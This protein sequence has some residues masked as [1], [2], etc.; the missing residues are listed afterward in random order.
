M[1]GM[2]S[3]H[4]IFSSLCILI[5]LFSFV[6]L[7][8]GRR[9]LSH[10]DAEKEVGHGIMA[11]G[12]LFMLAPAEWLSAD[13]LFWN[14]LVFAATSLWWTCRLIVRKP[15]LAPLLKKTVHV[16]VQSVV[17]SDTMQVFMH[18]GM[19]YLFLLMRNMGWSMT[20]PVTDVTCLLLILFALFTLFSGRE[21]S[22]DFQALSTDW[23]Q[24]SAHLVHVLMSGMM[25][26]M[27]FEMIIMTMTMKG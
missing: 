12:M 17:W 1:I 4:M 24:L 7:V 5:A 2:S 27:F 25:C 13:L 16:P 15:L 22:Q 8:S 9:C 19:C 26:W 6:R 23:L 21:I 11:I 10:V 3:L 20:Q 18:G 14:M